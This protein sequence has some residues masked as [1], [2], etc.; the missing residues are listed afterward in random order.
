MKKLDT[1][2]LNMLQTLLNEISIE[3][4]SDEELKKI[5]ENSKNMKN[6]LNDLFYKYGEDKVIDIDIIRDIDNINL[7]NLLK[8]YLYIND[9][10]ILDYET[11]EEDKELEDEKEINEEQIYD[12][13]DDVKIYLNEI[14]NYP[15]LTIEEEAELFKKYN[16]CN[17][18]KI[19]R[20]IEESNLRLVVS[21]AKR[22]VG[23]GMNFLDLI[24]EGNI[25]LMKA[26]D[27]FDVSKGYKFSTYATW[28][29]RQAITRSIA[30][31]ARVIRM[32]VHM[33]ERVNKIERIKNKFYIENLRNPSIEELVKITNMPEDVIKKSLFYSQKLISL[34][35]PVGEEQHGAVDTIIDFVV[36]EHHSVEEIV[37][38]SKLKE[39]VAEVLEELSEK[40]R[41]I[42][43][44]RFGFEDGRTRTLEEI[45][46]IYGLTRERIRQLEA[47][48]L[49]KLKN[50]KRSN[51]LKDFYEED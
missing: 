47:K 39:A 4:L 48:A 24:Q 5:I 30:D 34:D 11:L 45:G 13:I 40:E 6:L 23:R 14:G 20:K 16:E 22:Y 9:Y 1:N 25:G 10:T 37:I 50:P 28:W 15:L 21:I 32:P 8:V 31:Q 36:D 18:L 41:N 26:V 43:I 27:K 42:V 46:Q 29:I 38:K 51:K 2:K 33:I 19:K 35:Q 3:N 44:L 17:D 7:I 12:G 49:R